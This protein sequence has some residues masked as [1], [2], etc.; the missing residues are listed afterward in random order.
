M[1]AGSHLEQR[2][3]NIDFDGLLVDPPPEGWKPQAALDGWQSCETSQATLP[4]FATPRPSQE[5]VDARQ[6]LEELKQRVRPEWLTGPASSIEHELARRRHVTEVRKLERVVGN[7]SHPYGWCSDNS[8]ASLRDF[9]ATIA[10]YPSSASLLQQHPVSTQQ[11]V[12]GVFP[13][14][15]DVVASDV[16]VERK[17]RFGSLLF[18]L[19]VE[20]CASRGGIRVHAM[21]VESLSHCHADLCDADVQSLFNY[22]ASKSSSSLSRWVM[23]RPESCSAHDEELN[24]FLTCLLD[25]VFFEV[26]QSG[27]LLQL[28]LPAR[29]EPV[30]ID[31]PVL[32]ETSVPATPSSPLK[33]SWIRQHILMPGHVCTEHAKRRR[34]TSSTRAG[35]VS[36]RP[37]SASNHRSYS[38]YSPQEGSPNDMQ[39][40]ERASSACSH[41]SYDVYSS[42]DCRSHNMQAQ[43]PLKARASRPQSAR[44]PSVSTSVDGV[45]SRETVG[46]RNHTGSHHS[47][48][49]SAHMVGANLY[50]RQVRGSGYPPQ[51]PPRPPLPA[52]NR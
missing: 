43:E 32:T 30:S 35:S 34:P 51:H 36:L 50:R 28:R 20:D 6:A 45:F 26:D 46:S 24:E 7:T 18:R 27:A 17:R 48:Q 21:D 5:V 16:L 25:A 12:C 42:Q 22:F 52:S 13:R 31:A 49:D 3:R 2:L 41:R 8:R 40:R 11:P 38:V 19:W 4:S 33:A 15:H 9:S 37:S 10:G 23:G 29:V 47:S 14:Q 44:R 1:A 39:A